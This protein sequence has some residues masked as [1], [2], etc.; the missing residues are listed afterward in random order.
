MESLI[1]L[2]VLL[3]LAVPVIAIIALVTSLS[4]GSRLTALERR[5]V[6]LAANDRVL[7][8]LTTRVSAL[9]GRTDAAGLAPPREASSPTAPAAPVA[10]PPPE[11]PASTA[12][13]PPEAVAT[14]AMPPRIAPHA[15]PSTPPRPARA[16]TSS[17]EERFGTRWVVWIGGVA[18]ALGGIFL[19][20]YS[21]Q[22]GWIG[23]GVRIALGALL[24]ALLIAAGEWLRRR[25]KSGESP[26]VGGIPAAHIPSILTAAGTTVAYATVFAAY[27]L[28]DFVGPGA[29]FVLLG[30]VALATLAAALLHGPALA[31]LGLVGA[32]VVPMLVRSPTPNYWALFIYLAVVTA[33]A[34]ALASTRLWRWL[35]ITAV[36]FGLVWTMA[37]ATGPADTA[38]LP[39]LFHVIVG[40][41][42]AALLV[43]AGLYFGPEVAP[44]RIDGMSSAS[45]AAYLLAAAIIVVL[46]SHPS[47]ALIVFAALTAAAAAI[48]W[49]SEA[50]VGA[51][52]AAALLAALVLISWAVPY[53]FAHLVAPLLGTRLAPEPSA[54]DIG[55]HVVLGAFFALMFGAAGYLAQGRYER[56][57][58]PIIWAATAVGAPLAILIALY[59]RIYGLERSLPFA[60]L[61]LLLAAW[62]A[63]AT[64]QLTRRPPRAGLPSAAAL[65]AAGSAAALA[66]TL[67]FA[68]E[69][70]WLTVGLALMAPGVAWVAEKRPLPMLRWIAAAVAAL[71]LA[72][73]AWE[74]RIVGADVGTTPFFNW[75]LYGY[76]VP[77]LAF[78]TAG[79]LLRRRRD[80]VPS[81]IMDAAAILFTVLFGFLEVRHAMNGGDIYASRGGLAETALH[82]AVGLAI[83]IGLE[84]LRVRT[85]NVVHNVA[86]LI[87]A[88]LSLFGIVFGLFGFDLPLV[89]EKPVGGVFLNLLLLG[90]ALPAVLAITLAL[91]AKSTRPIPYRAVAAGVA[92]LLGLAY[93]TLQVM[94]LYHGPVL[95]QG[96]IGDAEQYTF[97]AVWLA[98]GVVLLGVGFLINSKPARLAA[99]AVILLTIA[100]VF[101]IDLAGLAGIWRALSF[102][103][104]GLVLVGI[105]YVYQRSGIARG[106][107]GGQVPGDRIPA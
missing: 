48:A 82:V 50:A 2:G 65:H 103:G 89:T 94:R 81:R 45:L 49:R 63:V 52:P 24:A 40:F 87:V 59:Y 67:S 4:A 69:K 98:Y 15:P 77:A 10:P 105:G 101:V 17:F 26:A 107:T 96:P 104:L 61:A 7:Q 12:A 72:R 21:I 11:V 33:A 54:T 90:Y 29:A 25:E 3:L 51:L 6:A 64:E 97:S 73:I 84:R 86:A 41:A 9:E 70:G 35:A 88:A 68:L 28:Y 57:A 34:F 37:G 79:Y 83:A 99:A 19:V 95:T 22:Q 5:I 85:R 100:K 31:A 42:L 23:P 53:D 46:Q 56:A 38:L 60:G 102:I 75:L 27:A 16:P 14:P 78:W 92:V 8:L 62:C 106:E 13:P 30:I 44:G 20:R 39:S 18:L 43:V 80:D 36:A 1:V 71:V 93:L 76:G 58:P 47:E 32:E 55:R 66:L 74:P 91:M